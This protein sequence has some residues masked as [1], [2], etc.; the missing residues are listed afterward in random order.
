MWWSAVGEYGCWEATCSS[1]S[2]SD[3]E[4]RI[5]ILIGFDSIDRMMIMQINREHLMELKEFLIDLE[6]FS[7]DGGVM[8]GGTVQWIVWSSG[9]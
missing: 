2:K 8:A 5:N 3:S 4:N 6:R 7:V 1:W 9:R